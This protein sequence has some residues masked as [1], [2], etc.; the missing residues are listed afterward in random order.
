MIRLERG[1]PVQMLHPGR[2]EHYL[3]VQQL[4][5]GEYQRV[6]LGGIPVVRGIPSGRIAHDPPVRRRAGGG[7]M[8]QA[9]REQG[10]GE[11]SPKFGSRKHQAIFAAAGPPANDGSRPVPPARLY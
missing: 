7:A 1:K 8:A 10:A 6:D 11:N 5:E 9:G 4:G 3:A 2:I